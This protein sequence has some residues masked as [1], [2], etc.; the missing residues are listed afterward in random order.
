MRGPGYYLVTDM[1]VA[2]GHTREQASAA[3]A[4]IEWDVLDAV[5][6]TV[7]STGRRFPADRDGDG[8][9]DGWH[10]SS[11]AVNARLAEFAERSRV[12]AE[13]GGISV[14]SA[15]NPP[16]PFSPPPPSPELRDVRTVVEDLFHGLVGERPYDVAGD[17]LTDHVLYAVRWLVTEPGYTDHLTAFTRDRERE[18]RQMFADFGPGSPHDTDPDVWP[19]PRYVLARQPESLLLAHLLTHKHLSLAGAWEDVLPD[20]LLDDMAE[21]WPYRS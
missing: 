18:L 4:R 17:E 15:P 14:P 1:L 16:I 11:I 9:T 13:R 5:Q 20:V 3:V 6:G 12:E 10:D 19:V 21:A 8:Y 7:S 2:A